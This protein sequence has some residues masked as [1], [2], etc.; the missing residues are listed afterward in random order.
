MS[1]SHAALL[2]RR[3]NLI[4]IGAITIGI[5]ITIS[6]ITSDVVTN[7]SDC[8]SRSEIPNLQKLRSYLK[9]SFIDFLVP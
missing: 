4:V 7:H 8:E 2:I 6:V 5:P 1:A 3:L 9:I